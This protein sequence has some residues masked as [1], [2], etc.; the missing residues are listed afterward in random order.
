MARLRLDKVFP[1]SCSGAVAAPQQCQHAAQITTVYSGRRTWS[2]APSLCGRLV[3]RVYASTA[4]RWSYNKVISC[5][6][7]RSNAF[8]TANYCND[9]VRHKCQHLNWTEIRCSAACGCE[10]P[11]P[12]QVLRLQSCL[13]LH[14]AKPLNTVPMIPTLNSKGH[15][16]SMHVP[17]LSC[18]FCIRSAHL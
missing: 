1:I 9:E 3:E 15:D 7:S 5:H 11:A 18:T 10:D 16:C 12:A 14:D 8:D 17:L 13:L 2:L 6:R 4:A